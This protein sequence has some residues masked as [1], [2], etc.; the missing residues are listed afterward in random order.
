MGCRGRS[1]ELW[2]KIWGVC[3]LRV[4]VGKCVGVWGDWGR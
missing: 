4:D 1:G 2:E 3:G